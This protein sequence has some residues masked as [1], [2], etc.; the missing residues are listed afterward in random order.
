MEGRVKL[1]RALE[2]T[3]AHGHPWVYRDALDRSGGPPGSVLTLLDRRGKFLARGLAEAGPIG[4][5]VWTTRDEPVDAT[6]IATRIESA[7]ALRDQVVPPATDAYRLVHGEGD[8]LP[9]LVCDRYAAFAVLRFDGQ[10]ILAW[11]DPLIEALGA[12]LASRGVPNLLVRSGRGESKRL[13][14]VR[15]DAP[16][17]V[18]DITE[19]GMSLLADLRHGQK[20]GLFLDHRESR[21]R[22]RALA[23]GRRVL[24]LY[25]YTGGFSIA[26]GLGGASFVTTVDVAAGAIELASRGWLANELSADR[27]DARAVDA[28]S[29]LADAAASGERWSLIIADP[30]SFAPND[31]ARTKALKAYK[32]L[33]R[34]VLEVLEPGGLYLAASCSSHV[35]RATFEQSLREAGHGAR[36]SLQVIGRWG[37]GPDH[38]VRLGFPEGDYLKVVLVRAD[39]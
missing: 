26:A 20:T 18:L 34:G 10:G 11:R 38:P 23:G 16:A 3:V 7:L 21:H 6:L 22:V 36:R 12:A 35:D 15:G 2:R 8:R 30:P 28:R 25:G 5:R 17:A 14:L 24:N 31:A 19:R 1:V 39:D 27:H 37:A 33:H 4:L 13:E 9:G 32:A 29:F